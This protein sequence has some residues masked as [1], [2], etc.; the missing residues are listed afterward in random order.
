MYKWSNSKK[1]LLALGFVC[2]AFLSSSLLINSNFNSSDDNTIPVF[3]SAE[4]APPARIS[5]PSIGV[6]AKVSPVGRTKDGAMESPKGP[7]DAAWFEPGPIPGE[8]GSAVIAGHRGWKL[9]HAIFDDLHK[10]KLGDKVYVEDEKG[11]TLAFVVRKIKIYGAEE[12]VPEVWDKDDSS[13]LNLIT[14]SGDWNI[15]TG[16]SEDRLVVSTELVT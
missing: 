8:R 7:E 9:R 16:T 12:V 10:I 2:T 13:Y 3:A 5:I 4:K 11:T 6:D 1:Y 15:L 14:C